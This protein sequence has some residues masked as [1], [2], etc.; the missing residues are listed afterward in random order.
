MSNIDFIDKLATQTRL[1]TKSLGIVDAINSASDGLF[2]LSEALDM[3]RDKISGYELE[4]KL[5]KIRNCG[6]VLEW[7]GNGDKMELHNANFC[8][9]PDGCPICSKRLQK[10][11]VRRFKDP[12]VLAAKEFKYA[13]FITFTVSNGPDLRTCI[14]DLTDGM[15]RFRLKGQ[16]R[17]SIHSGGEWKKVKAGMI[18]IEIKRGDNS[19]LWHPH[20]HGLVFTDEKIDYRANREILFNGKKVKASKLSCE[21]IAATEGRSINVDCRPLFKRK[22]VKKGKEIWLDVWNQSLEILKYN[23]K[24]LNGAGTAN[25]FDLATII[26]AGYAKR[27]FNTYG[28]FRNRESALYCGPLEPYVVDTS[29][30]VGAR[31]KV[32]AQYWEG[33]QYGQLRERSRPLFEEMKKSE[34][35]GLAAGIQGKFR[36]RKYRILGIRNYFIKRN[37]LN[38]FETALADNEKRKLSALRE[39]REDF[40]D[41]RDSEELIER[42][43]KKAAQQFSRTLEAEDFIEEWYDG[44]PPENLPLGARPADYAKLKTNSA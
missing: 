33:E 36:T 24:L 14:E 13:Y 30:T 5:E 17:G 28:E 8:R 20:A 21:W 26:C 9:Q 6:T 16:K 7:R 42:M 12:I 18:S 38:E 19:N 22:V 27:K 2:P 25:S 31:P 29:E 23:T 11:R 15:K 10:N 35:R 43:M 4:R 34:W 3:E 32:Y 41:T 39:A 1:K 44:I 37:K 40:F